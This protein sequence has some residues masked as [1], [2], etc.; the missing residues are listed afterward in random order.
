MGIGCCRI[1]KSPALGHIAL[2]SQ[3]Y[4]LRTKHHTSQRPTAHREVL[5]KRMFDAS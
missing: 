2:T 4:L 1:P 5:I 3:F